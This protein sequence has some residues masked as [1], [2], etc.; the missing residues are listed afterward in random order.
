MRV[1]FASNDDAQRRM[2]FRSKLENG[3]MRLNV[4]LSLMH[5]NLLRDIQ[6]MILW[7]IA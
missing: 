3:E 6:L 1:G 7:V 4:M 2:L 5:L